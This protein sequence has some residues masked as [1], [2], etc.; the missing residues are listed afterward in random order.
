MRKRLVYIILTVVLFGIE[1]LI[2]LFADGWVRSYLGDVLVVILLYTICRSVSPDRPVKWYVLP[3]AILI[4]SFIVELLQLWGFCDRFGITN[5]FLR[6]IIG[7]GFSVVDLVCYC[8]GII[9]C[10]L[11]EFMIWSRNNILDR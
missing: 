1:V 6:I 2:G 10:Y 9:P 5:N 7:T 8:I 11:A 3:T 4:F